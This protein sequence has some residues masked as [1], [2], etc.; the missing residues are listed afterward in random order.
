MNTTIF[1]LVPIVAWALLKE[2][3][4]KLPLIELNMALVPEACYPASGGKAKT[5]PKGRRK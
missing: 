1:R 4:R 2:A 3:Q 5:E